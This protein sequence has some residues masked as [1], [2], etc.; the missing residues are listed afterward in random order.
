MAP[1][2]SSHYIFIGQHD[3]R[4]WEIQRSRDLSKVTN[5]VNNSSKNFERGSG[6][7][8]RLCF[9]F[10]SCPVTLM[11]FI[12]WWRQTFCLQPRPRLWMLV[13]YIQLPTQ[14]FIWLPNSI[15]NVTW[16]F[17]P[18]FFPSTKPTLHPTLLLVQFSPISVRPQ[19]SKVTMTMLVVSWPT[20]NTSASSLSPTCECTQCLLLLSTLPSGPSHLCLAHG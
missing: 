16:L 18:F 15:S 2:C 4:N 10:S 6:L 14:Y 19:T 9:P 17:E 13:S 12:R 5:Q 20:G 8:L 3:I 7:G 11:L 1:F